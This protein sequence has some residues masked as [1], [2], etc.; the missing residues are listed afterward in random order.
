MDETAPFGY[1]PDTAAAVL[2]VLQECVGTA[3]DWIRQ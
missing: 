1:R 3:L 2:P